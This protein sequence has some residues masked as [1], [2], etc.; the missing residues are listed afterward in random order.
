MRYPT[1][2]TTRW[3]AVLS[4]FTVLGGDF[5]RDL[6]GVWGYVALAAVIVAAA[7]VLLSRRR[8]WRRIVVSRLPRTL[9][10]L[11]VLMLVSIA[12]SASPGASALGVLAQAATTLA[13]LALCVM[14]SWPGILAALAT[15]A[16]WVVGLSLVF[17]FILGAFVRTP[18][19]PLWTPVGPAATPWSNADLFHAGPLQGIVGDADALGLVAAFAI[20]AVGVQLAQRAR[21]RVP[22]LV[23][24]VA[25]GVTLA[26]TRSLTAMVALAAA[27]VM[28]GLV[29]LA[30]RVGHGGRAGV[31]A[32]I[33]AFTVLAVAAFWIFWQPI[34]TLFGSTAD[35]TSRAGL[36]STVAD[37]AAQ[38]PAFGWGWV[39]A[40]P[41]WTDL[42]SGLS[43]QTGTTQAH[44]A[45]LEI[46]LRLGVVGLI[47]F[48]ALVVGTF[49]RLWWFAVDHPL[50]ALG[51]P[52]RHV[53]VT[54]F[55]VLVLTALVVA[56]VVDSGLIAGGGWLLLVVLAAKSKL[57][58]GD[59]DLELGDGEADAS[60]GDS[61][62]VLARRRREQEQQP[63]RQPA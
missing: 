60:A 61:R 14:L 12:W 19:Y 25:A 26:L 18:V 8:A 48:I 53:P 33:G 22:A 40:W 58:L 31:L 6:I 62:G 10:L 29:I 56:S 7:A 4:L 47:L 23:W 41:T 9:V 20:I 54:I 28:L 37:L 45:W 2:A 52:R 59:A 46:L 27:A 30:R 38:R 24:I 57:E 44:N 34:L 42:F 17:E 43:A 3:L 49:Y 11:L 21:P 16:N 50:D 51:L 35:P 13:A 63:E 55:P 32:G 39:G 15:A 5:W 36:W 1:D